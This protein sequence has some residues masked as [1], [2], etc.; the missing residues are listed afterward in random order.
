MDIQAETEAREGHRKL[1]SKRLL[2][3]ETNIKEE[4]EAGNLTVFDACKAEQGL[5]LYKRLKKEDKP[6]LP[7]KLPNPWNRDMPVY[8][9]R[10]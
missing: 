5:A 1:L 6:D 8:T 9:D 4:M 3:G 2:T 7:D 10:K